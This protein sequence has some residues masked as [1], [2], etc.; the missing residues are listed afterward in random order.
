MSAINEIA[1]APYQFHPQNTGAQKSQA[2]VIESIAPWFNRIRQSADTHDVEAQAW[3]QGFNISRKNIPILEAYAGEITKANIGNVAV[4]GYLGCNIV[5][6]LN[7]ATAEAP[8]VVWE[9]VCRT[10]AAMRN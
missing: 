10:M 2:E 6:D 9:Q 3:M 7:P 8:A 5:T 1:V 4:W